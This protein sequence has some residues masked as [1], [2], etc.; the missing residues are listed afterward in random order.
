MNTILTLFFLI[1][2]NLNEM[3]QKKVRKMREHIKK[4]RRVG[5]KDNE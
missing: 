2:F 1:S 3:T 5:E 4:E